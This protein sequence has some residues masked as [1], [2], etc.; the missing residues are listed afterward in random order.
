MDGKRVN[1][2]LF[3]ER[4]I[5]VPKQPQKRRRR[6]ALPK[7]GT[8]CRGLQMDRVSCTLRTAAR[9]WTNTTRSVRTGVPLAVLRS[10]SRLLSKQLGRLPETPGQPQRM[11][12]EVSLTYYRDTNGNVRFHWDFLP[13]SKEWKDWVAKY[14]L[15][16]SRQLNPNS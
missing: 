2:D 13:V 5:P 15:V 6:A 8:F 10:P 9:I 1:Q 16:F 14:S 7:C 3:I 12:A 11:S 4:R